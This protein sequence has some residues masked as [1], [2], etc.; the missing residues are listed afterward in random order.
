MKSAIFALLAAFIGLN[1]VSAGSLTEEQY[2]FLFTKWVQQNKKVYENSNS[3]FSKYSTF[4]SNVD[5]IIAHNS[6]GKSYTLA[7]NQFADLTQQEFSK[8]MGLKTINKKATVA[9]TTTPP[10]AKR[11][12]SK[13]KADWSEHMTGV[14]NQGSCGSCWSFSATGPIEALYHKK[15]GQQV[16]LAE[17]QLVDC[18]TSAFDPSFISEGCNGGLMSEANSY[19]TKVGLCLEAD[20]PYTARDGRCQPCDGKVQLK[21][22]KEVRGMDSLLEEI[23][24]APISIGIAASSSA[25]QFYSKGI[26][27]NCTDTRLNHGVVLVGVVSDPSSSALEDNY[28]YVRNSWGVSWGDAGHIKLSTRGNQCGVGRSPWDVIPIV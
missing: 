19:A 24:D 26:V 25:F 27:D 1:A 8:F 13:F 17:Q 5:L 18:V 20:Y 7:I 23:K 12:A 10:C 15:T 28:M 6:A 2:Q 3:I 21:G 22:Y 14:K 16:V 4:K 9:E 11:A